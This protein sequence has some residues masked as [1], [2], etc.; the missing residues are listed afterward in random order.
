MQKNNL[1]ENIIASI[2]Y[3]IKVSHIQKKRF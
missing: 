3:I 2:Y 1:Q